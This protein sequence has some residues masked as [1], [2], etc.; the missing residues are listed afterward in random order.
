MST[1]VTSSCNLKVQVGVKKN[2]KTSNCSFLVS[3]KNVS[4]SYRSPCCEFVVTHTADAVISAVFRLGPWEEVHGYLVRGDVVHDYVVPACGE[5]GL[6]VAKC[7][8]DHMC[9]LMYRMHV[10]ESG[11]FVAVSV[12]RSLKDV[13]VLHFPVVLG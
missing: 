10:N 12:S 11:M 7:R 3:S 9:T 1:A 5:K 2:T 6:E 8:P 13:G 4:H